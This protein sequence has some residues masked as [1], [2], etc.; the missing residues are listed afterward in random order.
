V[1]EDVIHSSSPVKRATRT[2][3]PAVTAAAI[4]HRRITNNNVVESSEEESELEEEQEDGDGAGA[5]NADA[6]GAG[7][8]RQQRENQRMIGEM[9]ALITSKN[10]ALEQKDAQL[11]ETL[12]ELADLRDQLQS[13]KS[14]CQDVLR[15]REICMTELGNAKKEKAQLARSLEKEVARHQSTRMALNQATNEISTLKQ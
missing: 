5:S 2:S 4:R 11:A 9:R 10:T 8:A 14:E 1:Q 3:S 7:N 12:V 13:S 15:R 6:A